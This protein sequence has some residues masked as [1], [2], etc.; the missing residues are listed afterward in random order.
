MNQLQG[1]EIH[2]EGITFMEMSL[3]DEVNEVT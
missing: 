3:I 2:R 1:G